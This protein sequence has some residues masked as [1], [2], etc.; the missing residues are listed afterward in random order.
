MSA[1]AP[2]WHIIIN[3]QGV[4]ST[5]SLSSLL[6]QQKSHFAQLIDSNRQMP[7][8]ADEYVGH[9]AA[10]SHDQNPVSRSALQTAIIEYAYRWSGLSGFTGVVGIGVAV[11]WF[12]Y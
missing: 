4:S 2:Y 8:S 5:R 12:D 1:K 6:L 10:R 3:G 7:R 11:Q 9:V